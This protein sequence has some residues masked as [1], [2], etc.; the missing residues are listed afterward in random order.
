MSAQQTERA[1]HDRI[2]DRLHIGLRSTDDAQD[3]AGGGLR[4]QRLAQ[5]AVA[6]L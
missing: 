4:V 2:E 6:G 3:V 1:H 5:V